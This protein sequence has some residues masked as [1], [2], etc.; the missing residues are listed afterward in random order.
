MSYLETKL[1]LLLSLP[2]WP[3]IAWLDANGFIP[4][5]V[6]IVSILALVAID[7]VTG[8]WASRIKGFKLSSGKMRALI[9]KI[10]LYLILL[11]AVAI[12]I[13]NIQIGDLKSWISGFVITALCVRELVSITENIGVIHPGLVPKWVRAKLADFDDDGKLNDTIKP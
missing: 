9:A 2:F 8:I 4:D 7:T 11:V 3:I 1:A 10:T 12:T 5:G 6:Q 13:R